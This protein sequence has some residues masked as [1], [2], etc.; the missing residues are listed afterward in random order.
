MLGEHLC[1]SLPF[2]VWCSAC[3]SAWCSTP[4]KREGRARRPTVRQAPRVWV[5]EE[6][7]L[8]ADVCCCCCC[9]LGVGVCSPSAAAVLECARSRELSH[10]ACLPVAVQK[11]SGA[12]ALVQHQLQ[13]RTASDGAGPAVVH[14]A[15]A[16]TAARNSLPT[17]AMSTSLNS[18]LVSPKAFHHQPSAL[19]SGSAPV[20]KPPDVSS[21]GL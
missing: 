4:L 13:L 17:A 18:S 1:F 9:C 6:A 7:S 11:R 10:S 20:F 19:F 21:P 14:A 16:A 3:V 5:L 8:L 12:P 2:V 15:R